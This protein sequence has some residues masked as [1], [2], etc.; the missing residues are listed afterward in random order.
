M[1]YFSWMRN[2]LHISDAFRSHGRPNHT[3]SHSTT[4]F[5]T[6]TTTVMTLQLKYQVQISQ[7]RIRIPI[8]FLCGP[9]QTISDTP[10]GA[11]LCCFSGAYSSQ[12]AY[13]SVVYGSRHVTGIPKVLDLVLQVD[14]DWTAT[15]TKRKAFKTLPSCIGTLFYRSSQSLK[16]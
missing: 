15:L 4:A 3:K 1:H 8:S 11:F 12:M 7:N 9:I 2:V 10:S 6:A 16:H 14:V 13:Q 5:F